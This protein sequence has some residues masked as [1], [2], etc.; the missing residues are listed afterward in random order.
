MKR[1]KNVLELKKV[2]RYIL[3]CENFVTHTNFNEIHNTIELLLLNEAKIAIKLDKPV[4]MSKKGE[5]VSELDLVGMKVTIKIMC[6]ELGITLD[7]VELNTSIMN[8]RHAG[9]TKHIVAKGTLC[10]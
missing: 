10:Q 2:V 3:Q 4:L 6:L 8:D 9:G 5:E 7:E 1:H